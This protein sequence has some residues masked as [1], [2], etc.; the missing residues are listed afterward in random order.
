MVCATSRS[1]ASLLS[2]LIPFTGLKQASSD[3]RK[4]LPRGV[5]NQLRAGGLSV[6]ELVDKVSVMSVEQHIKKHD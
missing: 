4:E 2:S 1:K 5:R 6:D 3:V